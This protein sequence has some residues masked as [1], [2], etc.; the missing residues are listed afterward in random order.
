[1]DLVST[2]VDEYAG[3]VDADHQDE[4]GHNLQN[5]ANK[6]ASAFDTDQNG[7]AP[8]ICSIKTHVGVIGCSDMTPS[9]NPLHALIVLKPICGSRI[10]AVRLS[11]A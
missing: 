11:R 6:T 1:M 7:A 4:V 3:N 2:V 10:R 8:P 9:Y 5:K